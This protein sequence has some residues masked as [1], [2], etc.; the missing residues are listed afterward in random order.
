MSNT[1]SGDDRLGKLAESFLARYRRGERPTPAEYAAQHPDLAEQIL[2][3][4][5]GLLLMEELGQG[6]TT[7]PHDSR[8][9]DSLPDRLGEYRIVREIGR[10]GMGV[11]YEAV[12]ETLGRRVALKVLPLRGGG[13]S[14]LGRFQREA[15]AAG[16]LHHGN[17]VP[18]F[19]VGEHQGVH[20]YAMQF[21]DG[22]GLDAVLREVK[23]TGPSSSG[24][25]LAA[26]STEE[27]FRWVAR[28]VLQVAEGLAHAHRQGVLHR[29]I[30]PSNLLLDPLGTVWIADFGLAWAEGAEEITQ[31]GDILGTLRYLAPERLG[32]ES[33]P[34]G[35]VYSLG[36]TL[37]EL[38]ALRPPFDDAD[39][40]RLLQ[41]IGHDEPPRPRSLESA[42]PRDLETI[43]LK[44]LE[45]DP[46]RRYG[47]ARELADDL[48]RFLAG[49]PIRA[50]PVS[51][52]ERVAKW[53]RRRPA[54]AGLSAACLLVA[55]VAFGVVIW[56]WREAER[57]RSGG[58]RGR[59]WL[60]VTKQ[61]IAWRAAG[62][63]RCARTP[64]NPRKPC[65]SRTP[66]C[67]PPGRWTIS[68][69]SWR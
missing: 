34:A 47:S 11:V 38:L 65:G 62:C 69:P 8:N 3:L 64:R 42:V 15:Q 50:R 48:G 45:K 35:D 20:Y 40:A 30:K 37:Y 41:R 13:A 17:I 22:Q 29:D 32:G 25:T 6:V 10:G 58:R 56:K 1:T 21:I 60:S 4:F 54:V 49:E 19:G 9:Q 16:R 39:R 66:A 52:M 43:C 28:L 7:P 57:R 59:A 5:P 67:W 31:T 23:R 36:A 61:V 24:R 53:T 46:K 2:E 44:C 26:Y 18:V 12:Q 51:V 27:Y 55:L 33:L 63:W 14:L 68:A